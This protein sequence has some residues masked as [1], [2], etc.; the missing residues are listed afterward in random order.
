MFD[1][2]R[3]GRTFHDA[4]QL[5]AFD[6]VAVSLPGLGDSTHLCLVPGRLLLWPEFRPG[7]RFGARI[8]LYGDPSP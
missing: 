3:V 8:Q 6:D 7:P 2:D 5:R 1:H 4:Q